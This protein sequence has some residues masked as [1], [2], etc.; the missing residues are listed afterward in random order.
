MGGGGW[1]GRWGDIDFVP[2]KHCLVQRNYVVTSVVHIQL[3]SEWE[4]KTVY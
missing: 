1:G 2:T 3:A 4:I